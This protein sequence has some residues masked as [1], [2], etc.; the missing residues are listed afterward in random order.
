[1]RN[2]IRRRIV[3]F[4][5]SIAVFSV[6]LTLIIFCILKAI[7]PADNL[8]KVNSETLNKIQC[9][10]ENCDIRSLIN[11]WNFEGSDYVVMKNNSFFI[12]NNFKYKNFDL[13][14]SD[15]KFIKK[16]STITSWNSPAQETWRLL[17]AQ[18]TVHNRLIEI[19]VGYVEKA[20][21]KLT[22][23]PA[24]SNV[25]LNL[26]MEINKMKDYIGQ[27]GD[28]SVLNINSNVD[29]YQIVESSTGKVLGWAGEM[30]AY[31]PGTKTFPNN[32][33]V[34]IEGPILYLSIRGDSD[35]LITFSI[36]EIVNILWLFI[37]LCFIFSFVFLLTYVVSDKFLK[38]YFILLKANPINIDEALKRGEGQEIE[39][40][41]G[42]IDEVILKSICAFANTNDGTLLLGIDD[43]AHVKG[44]T[45]ATPKEKEELV[46]K[47]FRLINDR[48]SPTLFVRVDFE[49]IRDCTVA[50]IFIPRGDEPLFY[51]DGRIYVRFGDSN[52]IA[53]PELVKKILTEHRLL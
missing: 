27:S 35:Q 1:M 46:H 21:W 23:T 19:L 37:F 8:H 22:P 49:I 33:S 36:I 25:D 44:L 51:L 42:I 14:Y 6:A 16:F 13:N 39:F 43:K 2:S 28:I 7:I 41:E 47:I 32:I 48:I 15:P 50:K 30:P 38:K 9:Y 10:G 40:K 29:G 52:V 17:S 3:I 18:V 24:D 4:S 12:K 20:S 11:D 5:L 31:F 45:I 34:F 53:Q 26:S